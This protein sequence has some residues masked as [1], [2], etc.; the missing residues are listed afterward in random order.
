LASRD[1]QRQCHLA[2]SDKVESVSKLFD[3][4]TTARNNLAHGGKFNAPMSMIG[5]PPDFA[6]NMDVRDA[7][8]LREAKAVL[9]HALEL[10][11][12][13]DIWCRFYTFD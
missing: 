3:A 12:C 9:L 11:K 8:L 1:R 4:I 2:K 6:N 7:K 10:P 13:K 5:L